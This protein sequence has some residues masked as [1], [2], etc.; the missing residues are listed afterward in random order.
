MRRRD[1]L[2]ELLCPAGDM[3][4]LYAAVEGGADA[5]Y[6]GGVRF[7]A[8]A[9]AKNFDTDGLRLAVNYCHLHSVR[10][11]VTVNTLLFDKELSAAVEFC[12]ELYAIGVD[13]VIC[14]DVGLISVLK[15][16]LPELEIHASTQL[17]V[18]NSVGADIAY[19][20]GCSRVVLA[21]ELS[22]NDIRR[23]VDSSRAEIEVFLHGALCVCHSGQCLFSSLVGGRSGNRGECAQPCRLPYGDGYPLSLKDLSL[24]EHIP[25]LIES[26]VTSLKIEGR[27]KS[28]AYV[29]TVTSVYR[30]LLDEGRAA[31][32]AECR[33]LA[34]AFSRGGF[35]DGY[36]TGRLSGMT[37]IRSERDKELT[38]GLEEEYTPKIRRVSVSAVAKIVAGEPIEFTISGGGRSYTAYGQVP[39]IA[40]SS[41]LEHS[42]VVAR[43]SKTGATMLELSGENIDLTLGEGLN[44]SPSV[45]NAL[46][47]DACLGFESSGR[48]APLSIEIP[49]EQR[50]APKPQSTALFLR[51]QLISLINER[52]LSYFDTVFVP[53][54]S[55]EALT[56]KYGVYIPP[57]VTDTE[58][59]EV[60]LRLSEAALSGAK[61]ALVSN[62]SHI[63]LASEVGLIGVGDFRLNITNRHARVAYSEL[64]IADA[65]LSAELGPAA[66]SNIGGGG[67]AYGRIPLMLTERCFMREGKCSGECPDFELCD[68]RGARFPILREWRHRN[69][70]LNSATTFIADKPRDLSMLSHKHFIFTTE[71]VS[72]AESAIAAYFEGVD[73]LPTKFRRIGTRQS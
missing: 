36:L 43:L 65:V 10:L 33:R 60:R 42:A 48:K 55:P 8:R 27:M 45:I 15:K 51:P 66:I 49:D 4:S 3:D 64:G 50:F 62:I 47:R 21:R 11:Y 26:G 20:L 30:R 17:S 16:T 25:Q 40:R 57:V 73:Y 44:L 71:C 52:L 70:I 22:L 13:A 5:I 24:A 32:R 34:S 31:T 9:F 63:A 23:A 1:K 19:S 53:L 72:E 58:L 67:V 38:R 28:P 68:R 46:R 35:T 54:F 56:G 7:G 2:P 29:Y 41:P 18:N 39:E 14:Q 6:V 61:H 69:L 59:K 37:G 12:R